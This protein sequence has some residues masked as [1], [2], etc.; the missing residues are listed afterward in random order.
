[1]AMF[2]DGTYLVNYGGA[3]RTLIDNVCSYVQ[4][5]TGTLGVD[6]MQVMADALETRI[7]GVTSAMAAHSSVRRLVIKITQPDRRYADRD[8]QR[9]DPGTVAFKQ[10]DITVGEVPIHSIRDFAYG[11][12]LGID[13]EMAKMRRYVS[14]SGEWVTNNNGRW[15]P[16]GLGATAVDAKEAWY[17]KRYQNWAKQPAAAWRMDG[18]TGA[19]IPIVRPLGD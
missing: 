17:R 11:T 13:V 9:P 2:D 14:T 7:G 1:M 10:G 18:I 3:D 5:S 8:L 19:T 15:F 4:A 16:V 6:G 12:L